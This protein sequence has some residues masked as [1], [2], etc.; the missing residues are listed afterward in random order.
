MEE[1]LYSPAY[2][3]NKW[4][5][6][7]DISPTQHIIFWFQIKFIPKIRLLY[8][9]ALV[10]ILSRVLSKRYY[11]FCVL[12]LWLYIR[13]LRFS[14]YDIS[15]ISDLSSGQQLFTFQNRAWPWRMCNLARH[16]QCIKPL[17]SL[18]IWLEYNMLHVF[19]P[20]YFYLD[21]IKIDKFN[22]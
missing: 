5:N 18:H 21:W 14:L 10:L 20:A 15:Q 1:L 13:R 7:E 19:L 3:D 12:F 9:S 11:P 16:V 6:A 17:E 4:R 22:N 2:F 8:F